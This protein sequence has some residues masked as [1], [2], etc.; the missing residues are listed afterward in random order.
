MELHA[1]FDKKSASQGL[2]ERGTVARVLE[3]DLIEDILWYRLE[4]GDITGWFPFKPDDIV[5]GNPSD[6]EANKEA[7]LEKFQR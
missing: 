5:V 1:T 4:C 6:L 3:K 2:C 7:Y